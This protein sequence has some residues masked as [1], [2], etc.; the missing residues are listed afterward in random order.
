M[1]QMLQLL[2]FNICNKICLI[3]GIYVASKA[4]LKSGQCIYA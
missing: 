2:S 1:S 4:S 3:K